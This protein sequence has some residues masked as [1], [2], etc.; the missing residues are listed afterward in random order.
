MIKEIKV[1]GERNSGTMYLNKLLRMNLL[2]CKILSGNFKKGWKHG[3]VSHDQPDKNTT[4]F[5]CVVRDLEE[6]LVSMRRR[7]YHIRIKQKTGLPKFLNME[8]N[9][10]DKRLNHPTRVDPNEYGRDIFDIR[11]IKIE[12]YKK[13]FKY[14]PN[15]VF[16]NLKTLQN[17]TEFVITNLCKI[18]KIKKRH[19]FE[20][21]TVHTKT[22][23]EEQ[24]DMTPIRPYSKP[25][26]NK[27]IMSKSN[28][29]VEEFINKLEK[30]VKYKFN[31]I[32]GTIR[33]P[34]LF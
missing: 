20:N 16:L 21:L 25:L 34:A 11:Y 2:N 19:R 7:P 27:I 12:S 30:C 31:N 23:K 22:G 10:S 29:L 32:E 26:V 9:S 24:I 4:L 28:S 6:W 3:V 14:C 15:V 33:I 8:I 5:I 18:F 1:F 17:N 13:L